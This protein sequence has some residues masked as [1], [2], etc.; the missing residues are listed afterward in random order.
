MSR[1]LL[2]VLIVLLA[3]FFAISSTFAQTV[4]SRTRVGNFPEGSAYVS[5]G[6]L[7]GN[8]VVL[9]GQ[10][11]FAFPLVKPRKGPGFAKAFDLKRLPIVGHPN[12]VA[13]IPQD[14]TFVF[15]EGWSPT[16]LFLSDATGK[17]LGTITVQY[18]NGWLPTWIEGIA[19]IPPDSPIYPDHFVTAAM[20]QPPGNPNDVRLEVIARD[21]T[22][23][24]EIH[25]AYPWNPS[26]PL[27]W[28]GDGLGGVEFLPGGTLLCGISSNL[29][30]Y[31]FAGA[32]VRVVPLDWG[33]MEGITR[34]PGGSFAG[35][36]YQV[37]MV[38]FFDANL[39]R[40]PTL[41]RSY[42]FAPGL[43]DFPSF[44]W[45]LDA[46]RYLMR[47]NYVPVTGFYDPGVW[48]MPSTLETSSELFGF[49][50]VGFPNR[51][52]YRDVT[53]MPDEHLMAILYRQDFSEGPLPP[54]GP[55]DCR[56][57]HPDIHLYDSFGNLVNIIH[58]SEVTYPNRN[59]IP[60]QL[61]YI[62]SLRQFVVRK[63]NPD[64]TPTPYALFVS[65]DTGA[66]V[67]Q[68]DLTDAGITNGF[69]SVTYFND[70]VDKLL[71]AAS[72]Q[73]MAATG[74]GGVLLREFD[75]ST[76]LGIL[77]FMNF[78][79]NAHFSVGADPGTFATMNAGEFIVFQLAATKKKK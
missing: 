8:I 31:T 78:M 56:P 43:N 37:G 14:K 68:L 36:G 50:Q 58:I 3:L 7:A 69:A 66:V 49:P 10:D 1:R 55:P 30:E 75:P 60:G 53:Y 67:R 52:Q 33:W 9:D 74:L 54:C 11:V 29:V 70:G 23:V 28:D 13:Y 26:E 65:R 35:V 62:P 64:G 32:I 5:T 63:A 4:V 2:R 73:R 46:H 48:A 19:Y 71:F 24:N 38:T 21:G 39:N 42:L 72:R 34:L 41:D 79:N 6:T 51:G 59:N 27:N 22:V 45:N 77:Y 76:T 57:P 20:L 18:L 17:S 47:L 12:G 25:P 61:T 44:A 40:T 15:T 16:T